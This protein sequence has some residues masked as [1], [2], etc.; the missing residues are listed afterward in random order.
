[1]SSTAE[2]RASDRW[3]VLA[4][5]LVAAPLAA[6]LVFMVLYSL[7]VV[8]MLADGFTLLHWARVLGDARTWITLGFSVWVGAASMAASLGLALALHAAFGAG[9]RERESES[10]GLWYAPLAVPPLV[11]ALFSVTVLGSAGLLSRLAH[12]FGWIASPREFPSPVYS[13]SGAGI[14]ITHVAL[15]T[16]FLVLLFERL[17]RNERLACLA[18][19][20][21]TLG[22]TAAQTWMRVR[23]PVLMRA[24]TPALCVYFLALTGALEVPLLVGAQYPPMISVAIERR[25][26]QF[27]ISTRPEAYALATLYAVLSAAVLLSVFSV[28]RKR[29]RRERGA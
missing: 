21:R 25:F 29:E 9:A 26:S 1:M 23:L 16:P 28:R 6:G 12:A 4:V 18:E 5:G 3:A 20:A 17:A 22:A 11:A 10:V 7:G 27:D 15:V 13:R 19:T 8:G 2:H 24:A 14:V